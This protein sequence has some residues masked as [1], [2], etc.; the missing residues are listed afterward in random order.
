M[1]GC[2]HFVRWKKTSVGINSTLQKRS[3][4][5]HLINCWKKNQY[6]ILLVVANECGRQAWLFEI[7]RVSKFYIEYFDYKGWESCTNDL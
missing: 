1:L 4:V 7:N 3:E 2:T 5:K 6:E